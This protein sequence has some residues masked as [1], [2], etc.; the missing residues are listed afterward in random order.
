MQALP[1]PSVLNESIYFDYAPPPTFAGHINRHP[2]KIIITSSNDTP[3]LISLSTKYSKSYQVQGQMNKWSFL[4]PENRFLDLSGNEITEIISKDTP[5]Y[6]DNDGNF[7]T[8]SGNFIGVSGYAEFYFIDDLYNYDF[9]FNDQKYTT[10]IAMLQTSG[11]DYFTSQSQ[12]IQSSRYSNSKAIAYQPHI[13]H[14]RDPDYIKI[15]ENG[16]RDFINPRWVPADQHIVFSFNWNKKYSEL[17][18]DGNE[19]T[20]IK[21]DSNFNKSIP[22]NTNT[23]TV[24]IQ[25]QL[26]NDDILAINNQFDKIE[27]SLNNFEKIILNLNDAP[28]TTPAGKYIYNENL[29]AANAILNYKSEL[30]QQVVEY[31]KYNY[32]T[33]LTDNALS[34]KC[35]RDVGYIIDAIVADLKNNT[36][37]RSIEVGNMYFKGT[38]MGM[39]NTGSSVPTLPQNQIDATVNAIKSLLYYINGENIVTVKPTTKINDLLEIF[40]QIILS[41][42]NTPATIPAG[43]ITN[44]SYLSASKNILKYKS[45]LQ[46]QV[47]NYANYFYPYAMGSNATL[48]AYCYRDSG[49][50]IDAI[51]AD[52]A[53]NTNHRSIEV[54]NM[55]FKG[56]TKNVIYGNGSTTP[57]I[58][59]DQLT[60]T[61][62]SIKSMAYYIN[63]NSI[64]T[65]IPS[66]TTTG[67]LSTVELGSA[68]QSDVVDRLNDVVYALQ[69]SGNLKQYN[70]L[71]TPTDQDI[72]TA[73]M[74][75]SNKTLLQSQVSNY[76]K[77][78]GYLK[79]SPPDPNLAV[80]CNRDIG[81][82]IDALVHD[83]NNGTNARSIEYAL[84]YWNGSTTRLPDSLVPN[85]KAK[86]IDTINKLKSCILALSQTLRKTIPTQ[87]T[88]FTTT[89]ILSTIDLGLGKKNTIIDEISNI[90]YP[91]QN[92]GDLKKYSPEGS[93]T[94][95][96]ID[97]A[98]AIIANKE[99]IQHRV[100]SYV[101]GQGYLKDPAL[102]SKCNRD[103]GLMID[104]VAYDLETGVTARSI[105]Y[106]LAYWEGS[107]S[108]LPEN[109]IPNQIAK[110][111]DTIE[112]LKK[113]LFNLYKYESNKVII[114]AYFLNNKI[115]VKYKNEDQYLS[116]GYNKTIFNVG[117]RSTIAVAMTAHAEFLSPNIK[118]NVYSPKMWLS[119]PK[120]G[121]LGIAE[122]NFPKQFDLDKNSLSKAQIYNFDVPIVQ[123][124]YFMND[125]FATTGFHGINSIAVLPPPNFEA[126][127]TDGELN[128]LY[129]F[130]TKGQILSAIDLVKVVGDNFGLLVYNQ[131]S[132]TS[133]VLDRNQNLWITLYDSKFVLNLDKDGNFLGGLSLLQ[134]IEYVTPPSIDPD[135][136][137]KNQP[138]P[139]V[140]ETQNFVEPTFLDTDSLNNIWVTYS[141]Y[142]SGYL[143]KYDINNN[144][145]QT[146]SY[147]VRACP[148][149]LIIDNKDNVWV[150]LSNNI[151]NSLGYIEKRD[152]EGQLLSTFGP[153]MGVNEVTLD[154]EQN[155]WFTYSY[156]R[157]GYIDNIT[158]TV[159]TFNVSDNSDQFKYA[160]K[161]YVSTPTKNTDETALEGI[162][163]DLKGYLYV[164]NSVENQIYVYDT[165]TKL[166]VDKFY[167]NPQG[168]T[169]WTRTETG[170]TEIE[171][172]QW[173]KSLQA[174][175]D[176]MGTK[177]LN[178][179]NDK[180]DTYQISI[181]GNSC[182]LEFMAV[183]SKN[184]NSKV[185]HL[186]S[187]FYKHIE[188]NYYQIIEVTNKTTN[189]P[190]LVNDLFDI[191]KVNENYD[192][193]SQIKSYAIT[194]TLFESSYLFDQF[195]PSIYGYYPYNHQDFGIIS[196]E[197][198]SNF[199][200]N[201]N[202][203]DTC[204]IDKLYSLS[205]ATDTNTEDFLLNYPL[206]I[207]RLM[208]IFSINQTKLFGSVQKNQ[209]NFKTPS[210]DGQFNR[211]KLLTSTY[212]VTAG[213]PVILK[214]KSLNKY[215]LIQTGPFVGLNEYPLDYLVNS[216][217]INQTVG[218]AWQG[219]YEFYEF[220]P[221]ESSIYSNNIIDWDNPQTTISR[222]LTSVFD[223]VG[224]EQ[225]IDKIFS[226][227]FYTG[228]G[229]I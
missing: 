12:H 76:V 188:T 69:N 78:K 171:Y 218:G 226:Y 66:F 143:L 19:I 220:L 6:K 173:D 167:V 31:A 174:H 124:P 142:A 177:W 42:D 117:K 157:I 11:V 25:A 118:G 198:I 109:I 84:A 44:S 148:Q 41:Q 199:I 28:A 81:L 56:I 195:L 123:E 176:W 100:S 71:G 20:P 166:F 224:D 163:C 202:D 200:L 160:Q 219:Y 26:I 57:V 110:T 108:R 222:N 209:N 55:Y 204:E 181:T 170:P 225:T 121:M 115:E 96:D 73:N 227:H 114:R 168:F 67:I 7:N 54:G 79:V 15:S 80:L 49:Y 175:G 37:H 150:A 51:A 221:S 63:G 156:S 165:K 87:P 3:H 99:A 14:Y 30:Q 194:P 111:I 40:N 107:N 38:L 155:L 64:P 215:E 139:D 223:W 88:P 2:F 126:W 180:P 86:T 196:Y 59:S 151:W 48:S 212:S 162:T 119:N 34:A 216:I 203:I 197:K 104:A 21:F 92:K 191:F 211:G 193:S 154:R 147:P 85:H 58:P 36:N 161:P 133:V 179:Y 228:L 217:G 158:G 149:D 43:N 128:Y 153:I 90:I 75:I 186:A 120:A 145:L 214:T 5:L 9:A 144:I 229:I 122:Y 45:Q 152:T 213:V 136:N 130:G 24:N 50:I 70:P 134:D 141:N 35:Y 187:T 207:K 65:Q 102:I 189:E 39:E 208:D 125:R 172:N 192:L 47:I 10:I 68:R 138:Y 77:Q 95:R 46:Q 18:Y 17:F 169:F 32:P 82:M 4:R 184:F 127:A 91:I 29:Y 103:V 27:K 132:P 205:D 97:L 113:E 89:G 60:A 1:L 93:P 164:V 116:P 183:T 137:S 185:S 146:I 190:I 72:D 131:V 178:K 83:L 22:S 135:W 129:K 159:S 53:N 140:E 23:D 33:T 8:I 106:A 101:S 61:I 62:N 98:K 16:I 206:E 210:D 94:Q 201:N 182:K 112:T 74:L 105:Q 13:F 52:I